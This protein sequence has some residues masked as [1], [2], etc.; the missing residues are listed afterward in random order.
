MC[1]VECCCTI[2][3][4]ESPVTV[5]SD[6]ILHVLLLVDALD[7]DPSFVIQS[8][9]FEFLAKHHF[10]LN[11]WMR[12]GITYLN[13]SEEQE[14]RSHVASMFKTKTKKKG[15]GGNRGRTIKDET[16]L[17]EQRNAIYNFF[18]SPAATATED[19]VLKIYQRSPFRRLM[20][21]EAT[22]GCVV[23]L[24]FGGGSGRIFKSDSTHVGTLS[25]WKRALSGSPLSLGS[26]LSVPSLYR[27]PSEYVCRF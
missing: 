26:R 10:D 25:R 4:S 22:C 1:V 24:R 23:A 15:R 11:A 27:T 17:N 19:A 6:H 12:E 8:S 2:E 9:C 5:S 16:F 21:Y 20:I 7:H 13:A 3:I 14:L 18:E